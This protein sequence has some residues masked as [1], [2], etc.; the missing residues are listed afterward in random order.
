MLWFWMIAEPFQ[1][2]SLTGLQYVVSFLIHCSPLRNK[3]SLFAN[4]SLLTFWSM[5][6]KHYLPSS[7]EYMPPPI[8]YFL[9]KCTPGHSYCNPPAYKFWTRGNCPN[10]TQNYPAKVTRRECLL[11]WKNASVKCVIAAR[12]TENAADSCANDDDIVKDNDRH[13][14]SML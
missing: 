13:I 5:L 10:Q 1:S 2:D 7:P 11:R 12:S 3:F 14:F 4:E 9:K 6:E 8:I